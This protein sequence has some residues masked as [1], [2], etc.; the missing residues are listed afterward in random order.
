MDAEMV[1]HITKL[2]LDRKHE[3]KEFLVYY[4]TFTIKK[5]T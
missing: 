3:E 4:D 2:F 5:V 1:P